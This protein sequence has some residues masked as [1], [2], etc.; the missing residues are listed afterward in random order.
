MTLGKEFVNIK[1]DPKNK[2]ATLFASCPFLLSSLRA[3]HHRGQIRRGRKGAPM[4]VTEKTG[5]SASYVRHT[6]K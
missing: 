6:T 2:F 5:S 1:C 4:Y 3:P